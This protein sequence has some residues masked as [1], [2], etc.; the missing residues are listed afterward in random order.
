VFGFGRRKSHTQ[1]VRAELGESFGHFM[2]AATH[3]AGGVGA[4]V[5]PR[6]QVARGYLAPTA[7]K[8][9]NTATNGWGSTMTAIAPLA[10]AALAGASQAGTVAGRT[11]S[12]SI[13]TRSKNMKALS[14]RKKP[15]GRRRMSML[16]GLL[17][18]GAVAGAVGAIAMRRRNQEQ[19][20]AYDPARAMDAARNDG[21]AFTGA[22]PSGGGPSGGA[23]GSPA[24]GGPSG[25]AG[26]S[27]ASGGPSGGAGGSPASGGPSGTAGGSPASGGP[28]EPTRDVPKPKPASADKARERTAAADEKLSS[29][30]G[31]ITDSAKQAA[32]KSSAKPDGLLGSGGNPT[33]NSRN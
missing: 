19:W 4:T 18:A 33:R 1:L 13:T 17:A 2:Q 10:V 30:T 25:G 16:T 27:P 31:A 32:A 15:K 29:T 22:G 21:R 11:G 24:S 14:K 7:A 23:G 8:V 9:R 26:G 5:G 3:A 6:V 12:K 20:D 28:S